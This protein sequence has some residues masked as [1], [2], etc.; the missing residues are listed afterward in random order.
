MLGTMAALLNTS[1]IAPMFF[2]GE[3]PVKNPLRVAQAAAIIGAV[4]YVVALVLSFLLPP[5]LEEEHAAK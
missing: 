5:A 4:V 1:V 2:P 3:G